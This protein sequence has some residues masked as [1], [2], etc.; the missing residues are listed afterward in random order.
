V[1]ASFDRRPGKNF[2][3]RHFYKDENRGGQTECADRSPA[4]TSADRLRFRLEALRRSRGKTRR[5]GTNGG[6]FNRPRRQEPEALSKG[7]AND[8]VQAQSRGCAEPAAEYCF[9]AGPPRQDDQA[10]SF[11]RRGRRR[12]EPVRQRH[13]FRPSPDRRRRLAGR[14]GS[15]SAGNPEDRLFLRA[16]VFLL[17]KST[18]GGQDVDGL[19]PRPGLVTII[20]TF[21][22]SVRQPSD[23]FARQCDQ[24]H[25][26]HGECRRRPRGELPWYNQFDCTA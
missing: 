25:D 5:N 18:D 13:F 14:C 22:D 9:S 26:H 19:A 10:F 17:E 12:L 16:V 3:E 7:P 20:N 2:R 11:R 8:I 15:Q 4:P 6:I 21:W 1:C 24:G 23:H